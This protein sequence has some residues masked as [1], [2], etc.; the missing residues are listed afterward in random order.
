MMA[1]TWKFL[2]TTCWL[3]FAVLLVFFSVNNR[4]DI[5]LS[6]EPF[7]YLP[8]IPTY[9]LLF[10]GIFIGIIT[11]G[12][13]TGWL[14]LRGFAERR[15]AERRNRYLEGQVSALSEDAHKQRAREAHDAASD[16]TALTP[17]Q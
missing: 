9:G 13:V 6:L 14:R 15:K 16:T 3:A 2:R 7:G 17:P 1:S 11:A 4:Q 10:L 8:P 12:A 5:T